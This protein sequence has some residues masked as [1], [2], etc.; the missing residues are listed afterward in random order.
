MDKHWQWIL[1]GL[2]GVVAIDM[3]A[4]ASGKP[5]RKPFKSLYYPGDN[6][7]AWMGQTFIVR[8]PRGDYQIVA[9]QITKNIETDIGNSTDIVLLAVPAHAPY[10]EDVRFV[11]LGS[12]REYNVQVNVQPLP[13][14]ATGK[15]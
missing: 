5:K 4:S 15:K 12:K 3:V 7:D 8:L 11:E 2:A 9:S 6:V 14:P 1:G 10:S 13:P